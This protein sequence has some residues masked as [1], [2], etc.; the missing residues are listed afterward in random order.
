M[1]EPANHRGIPADFD[2]TGPRA[3]AR[4]KLI[5]EARI[6][7]E[8]FALMAKLPGLRASAPRGAGEPVM[9]VPGVSA[10][11]GWTAPLR[12]FLR[13]IGYDASGWGLGRNGGNAPKL[14]P[15]LTEEVERL[16]SAK[17]A[18]VRLI[19]WSLGGYLAREVA[20]DRPELVDRVISLGAP[21]VGG[22]S[23]TATASIYVRRGYDLDDISAQVLQREQTPIRIPVFAVFSRT[24][25]VVDWRACIDVFDNPLVEHHE[26]V[27]SHLGMVYSPRVFDLVARLLAKPVASE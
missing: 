13:F 14:V 10:D 20:R 7:V 16:S 1:Q 25:A 19:G 15:R 21:I 8:R 24:D 27:A 2:R 18:P 26:V 23:Y 4:W 6:V 12:D 3:P 9:V 22:P 17:C 5:R 11:D